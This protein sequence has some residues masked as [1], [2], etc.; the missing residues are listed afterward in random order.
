MSWH[1]D[2]FLL[3]VAI[4]GLITGGLMALSPTLA[5]ALA[6]LIVVGCPAAICCIALAL[7]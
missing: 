7:S 3:A 2:R 5:T 1:W 4:G 6:V